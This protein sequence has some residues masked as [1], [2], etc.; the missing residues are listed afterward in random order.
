M[1]L[2]QADLEAQEPCR[3]CGLPWIDDLGAF[4]PL[5]KMTAEE[6]VG[7]DRE[8]ARYQERHGNCRAAR[9]TLQGSRTQHC[10]YCC[11]PPPMSAE[12]TE[13]LRPLLEGIRARGDDPLHRARLVV[14]ELALTCGHVARKT[15]HPGHESYNLCGTVEC[16]EC[17]GEIMGILAA[18]RIGSAG[19]VGHVAD[20]PPRDKR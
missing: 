8:E 18:V 13:R 16:R 14:W 7:Y 19:E 6:R 17:G 3:G 12:T 4:P 15:Q 2:T 1:D 11:P 10:C 9:Q 5:M 20:L